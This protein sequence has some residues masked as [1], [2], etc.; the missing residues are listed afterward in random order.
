MNL[1]RYDL[2]TKQVRE[3]THYKEYDVKWPSLGTGSEASIV[4]EN[5]GYLYAFDLKTEKST[6]A[7][8]S[9]ESD[10]T[11]T[12]PTY[13]RAERFINSFSLSPS[14]ARALFGARGEIFTVPAKKGDV[15]NLTNSS[16]VRELWPAWSPD[17]KWISYFSD[18]TGEYELYIRPQDGAGEEKRITTDGAAYRYEP[19]WSPDSKK[20]LFGEK[21]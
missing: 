11:L 14:G 4:Y 7:P 17:G 12:R 19:K 21:P 18:Q 3:L 8:I 1:Y 15:R 20:I 10:L 9:V 13:V 5:G 6:L 16:G 2:K